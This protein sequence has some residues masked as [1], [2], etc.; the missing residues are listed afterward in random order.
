M[1]NIEFIPNIVNISVGTAVNQASGIAAT[2]ISPTALQQNTAVSLVPRAA[3]FQKALNSGVMLVR[4][5][6][7]GALSNIN[8]ADSVQICSDSVLS[9]YT[10]RDKR[11]EP[12]QN[13]SKIDPSMVN[14]YAHKG[15][16]EQPAGGGAG[17]PSG[18]MAL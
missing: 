4:S 17:D 1:P 13:Y 2:P 10:I 6:S 7:T 5:A 8:V 16:D 3:R 9:N 14:I 11:V 18:G 15:P 12:K